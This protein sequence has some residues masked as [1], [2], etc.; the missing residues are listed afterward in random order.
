MSWTK[1][2]KDF[3]ASSDNKTWTKI[4]KDC[5]A[6]EKAETYTKIGKG[7]WAK[8]FGKDDSDLPWM[9]NEKED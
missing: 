4:G 6:N 3:W 7:Q 8:S 9:A 2:G 5:W 1:I